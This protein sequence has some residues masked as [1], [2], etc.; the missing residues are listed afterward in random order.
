[1]LGLSDYASKACADHAFLQ[2]PHFCTH[3]TFPRS[4]AKSRI[5]PTS[6][7]P[8]LHSTNSC[9][10]AAPRTCSALLLLTVAAAF[11]GAQIHLPALHWR[12]EQPSRDWPIDPPFSLP[13]DR[14]RPYIRSVV[15]GCSCSFRPGPCLLVQRCEQLPRNSVR[16]LMMHAPAH[17]LVWS[18]CTQQHESKHERLKHSVWAH[19][20]CNAQPLNLDTIIAGRAPPSYPCIAAPILRPQT[21][22]ALVVYT[23]PLPACG[24]L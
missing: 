18:A 14:I 3:L 10:M 20:G 9:T 24:V 21:S 4:R 16:S 8:V 19:A 12:G 13:R 22:S 23:K 2:L 1:M 7:L 17:R 15:L 6:R 11:T 5:D